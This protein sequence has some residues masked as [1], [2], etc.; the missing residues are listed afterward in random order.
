MTEEAM[1]TGVIECA[2]CNR[3]GPLVEI[4]GYLKDAEAIFTAKERDGIVT[5]VALD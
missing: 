2:G 5:M 1:I 4:P 3:A